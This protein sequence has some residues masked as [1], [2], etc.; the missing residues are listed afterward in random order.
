M[1]QQVRKFQLLKK[2][3]I[4][5]YELHDYIEGCSESKINQKIHFN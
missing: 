2:K 4:M 3:Q 1:T 5:I